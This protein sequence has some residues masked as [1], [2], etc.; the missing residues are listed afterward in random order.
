MKSNTLNS[1]PLQ[2]CLLFL[3]ALWVVPQSFAQDAVIPDGPADEI[4]RRGALQQQLLERELVVGRHH[5]ALIED[6]TSLANASAELNLFTEAS[7]LYDRAI[8]IHR[9]NFGLYSAGQIPLYFTRIEYDARRGDWESVNESIDH[10][11][12]LLTEKSGGYGGELIEYLAQLS[13]V[14]LQAIAGDVAANRADHYREAAEAIYLAVSISEQLWGENDMRRVGLYYSLVKQFYLQSTAVEMRDDTAYALRAVVPGSTWVRPRRVV[15][16]R[17]YRAGQRLL[18]EIESILEVSAAQPA[19][20]LAMLDL[21][22]ADW[23]L[24]FNQ[25]T[26]ERG[27]NEAYAALQEASSDAHEVAQLFAKP[28]IL[29]IAEFY[30]S[31]ALAMD[32][33]M[34][35]GGF[36][37]HT[38]SSLSESDYQLHEWFREM[39]AVPFPVIAPTLGN[40]QAGQYTDV[41]LHF[42]LNSMNEVSRW[43]SGR[44][45]TRKSVVDEFQILSDSD[46]E[47]IDMDYLDDRLHTLSFRPRMVDGAVQP[48]EGTL[49][50]RA[51]VD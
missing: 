13:E 30:P 11:Y 47:D 25:D 3:L 33:G 39:P 10:V 42:R 12:W 37:S 21:Y 26:A 45:Q 50:Y 40:L 36:T 44:Y 38:G 17:F 34:T 9:L 22:R 43:V 7:S 14:H 16:A 2:G 32:A 46:A 4:A 31:M 5:P 8:Q 35:S 6:I 1:R 29:P 18:N 20:A 23:R 28:R 41:L 48:A 49:L 51:S 15:Q 19:E 24:L 27:Y